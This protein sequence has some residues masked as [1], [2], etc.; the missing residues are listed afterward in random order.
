MPLRPAR[1]TVGTSPTRLDSD[2]D[3]NAS[4]SVGIRNRGSVPIYI[5]DWD[6]TASTG[7]QLDPQ[8]AMR[9]DV[10]AK[11]S[12]WAVTASGTAEVHRIQLGTT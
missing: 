10:R 7:Y 8:G 1:V 3:T 11:D 6:V 12:V 9:F 2:A 4:A 5:G